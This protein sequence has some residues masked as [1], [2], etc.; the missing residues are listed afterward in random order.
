MTKKKESSSKRVEYLRNRQA[1]A[2]VKG[3]CVW[4]PEPAVRG[5]T[6]CAGCLDAQRGSYAMRRLAGA[7]VRCGKP[8]AG[9]CRC[10][11]CA[12]A[13]LEYRR[14]QREKKKDA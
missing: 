7:C 9:K 14:A 3:T 11:E 1:T 10:P 13:T 2:R 12:A 6:L 4:C 5:K 8:A